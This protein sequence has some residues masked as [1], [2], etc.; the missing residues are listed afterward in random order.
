MTYPDSKGVHFMAN[1]TS[2]ATKQLAQ[3]ILD[4]LERENGAL[5]SKS[6][7]AAGES[8]SS[9]E[10]QTAI[11]YLSTNGAIKSE[12]ERRGKRY[13]FVKKI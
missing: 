10:W 6:G 5:F 3:K 9:S 1:E 11:A 2:A 4:E 13:G 12:G 8:C 7:L